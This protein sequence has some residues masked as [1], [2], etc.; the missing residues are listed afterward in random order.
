MPNTDRTTAASASG[1]ASTCEV[2]VRTEGDLIVLALSGEV[3][4]SAANVLGAAYEEAVRSHRG[5][6]SASVLLDFAS[7]DYINS[8]GIA[9]IVSLLAKARAEGRAVIASGL[10]EHYRHIFE[11]T[12]LS[13][14]IKL[15]AD[16][17][18][19]TRAVSDGTTGGART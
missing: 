4:G 1:A 19:A 15:F 13:D 3:D 17:E 18:S 11:I 2:H 14:F 8:T 7:V 12:R 9:L 16:V 10:S 5:R 6:D